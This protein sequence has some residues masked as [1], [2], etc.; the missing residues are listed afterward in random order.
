MLDEERLPAC[1]RA[2]ASEKLSRRL[3]CLEQGL[4]DAF[5]RRVRFS[6]LFELPEEAERKKLWISMFPP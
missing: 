4:D 5:K 2:R 6:V 1:S 3:A